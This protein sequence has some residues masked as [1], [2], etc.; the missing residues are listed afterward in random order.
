MAQ[1]P[2]LQASASLS[3]REVGRRQALVYGLACSR[4]ARSGSNSSHVQAPQRIRAAMTVSRTLRR[5]AA[6]ALPFVAA[7][8]AAAPEPASRA[9]P[10]AERYAQLVIQER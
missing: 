6:A 8:S 3:R 1:I 5:V 9:S 7:A 10:A 2:V 4:R